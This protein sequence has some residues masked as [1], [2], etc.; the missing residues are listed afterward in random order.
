M[1]RLN[2]NATPISALRFGVFELDLK[3]GELRKDGV[4][5]GLAPQPF[6]I[7]ALLAGHA[8]KLVSR[9]EVQNQIWGSETFVD[10]DQGLNFAIKKIRGALGDDA[11][12]PRYIE[13]LPRR[14]YRFIAPVEKV[15]DG[16]IEAAEVSRPND[17]AS[18]LRASDS[19]AVCSEIPGAE[20]HSSGLPRTERPTNR[21]RLRY[22]VTLALGA[23]VALGIAV[24]ALDSGSLRQRFFAR[25]TPRQIQSIVVLPLENLSGD[26]AQDYFADGMTD[27]LTTDLAQNRTL[28]VI[29]RTSAMQY[30]GTKKPLLQIARELKVDAV[31]EGAVL[32][33]GNRVKITARLIQA[34]TDRHLWAK[35][36]ERD[37][38]D[39]IGLERE[40]ALAI[41]SEIRAELPLRQSKHLA[42]AR[43]VVPEAYEAYLKGRFFWNKFTSEGW[44]KG[45]EYF[46]GAIHIDPSY[47][48]AYAGLADC[49]LL[50]GT[51][52]IVPPREAMP[53]GIAAA[54]KSLE[55]E[56][57][58]A[59]AHFSLAFAKT[60]FEWD[61]IGAEREFKRGF[62]LNPSY[63]M[64]HNW[65]S[66]YLLSL[67]RFEEAISEQERARDFDP[68]SL[69]IN[70]NLSRT[71]VYA[72]QYDRAIEQGLK[73]VELD[74][75]FGLIHG[76]LMEAYVR[77]GMYKEAV[78]ERQRLVGDSN[79]AAKLEAVFKVSGY[80]G[81]L[82]RDIITMKDV[83]KRSYFPANILASIFAE[84][85]DKEEAVRWLEKAYE[86][87]DPAL[88][89]L[90]VAPEYDKLQSDPRFQALVLKVGFLR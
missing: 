57:S 35:S 4:P 60:T 29:S 54:Q 72:R 43:P 70:T 64:G 19:S 33:S 52:G 73:T 3:S 79:E 36:Y 66:L 61:W 74:P 31:V 28:L 88:A 2:L 9:E 55:L 84:L 83:S 82:R 16:A 7:L 49:H 21:T 77:K 34:A 47:A 40:A 80:R 90:K 69:I 48:P 86:E 68:L 1:V 71:L 65:Y 13:T 5:I 20:A 11:E 56:E 25:A 15:V 67:G 62:E 78:R 26:P 76:W 63:A 30:K 38:R 85:D 17:D 45:I 46:N 44:L 42:S 27:E 89:Q 87:R 59:E 8:G 81:I 10:F 39:I 24:A 23:I 6:K 41:A 51:Y 22:I 14:G 53:K 12:T 32:R 37:L 50:L 18:T 75:N 58:S